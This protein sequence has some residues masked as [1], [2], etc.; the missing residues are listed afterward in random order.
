MCR[1]KNQAIALCLLAAGS[2][3]P[4]TTSRHR[5]QVDAMLMEDYAQ[6]SRD[7]SSQVIIQSRSCSRPWTH[8]S[9]AHLHSLRSGHWNDRARIRQ[10]CR[11]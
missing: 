2:P 6:S 1:A 8:K 9:D 10:E 5:V 4:S 7:A 11:R 3:A